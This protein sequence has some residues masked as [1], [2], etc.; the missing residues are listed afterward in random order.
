MSSEPLQISSVRLVYVQDTDSCAPA[1]TSE[2]VIETHDAGGGPYVTLTT[3]RWAI[4]PEDI[5]AFAAALKGAIALI[6]EKDSVAV[7]EP[8]HLTLPLPAKELSPNARVHWAKKAKAAKSQRMGAQIRAMLAANG[9]T[10]CWT[11]AQTR[12]VFYFPTNR[13]RD[14]DN[15]QA[16]LKAAWDGIADAGVIA[17]DSGLVHL[18]PEM[19]IDKAN[20]RV[21][22]SIVAIE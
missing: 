19:R 20:P 15:A 18:P 10:P 12:A 13:R 5:D 4:D 9:R 1:G 11:R 8:L 7:T 3:E 22:I 2:L 21:E 17:N 6:P 16:A 14:M